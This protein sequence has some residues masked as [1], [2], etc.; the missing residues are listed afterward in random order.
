MV[1]NDLAYALIGKLE[2]EP[3]LLMRSQSSSSE[4]NSDDMRSQAVSGVVS[5]SEQSHLHVRK[6]PKRHKEDSNR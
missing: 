5:G 4:I 6:Y 2:H 1:L 3:I